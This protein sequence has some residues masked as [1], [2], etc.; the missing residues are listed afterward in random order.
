VWE[1]GEPPP[2]PAN[3]VPMAATVAQVLP[4]VENA[5]GRAL[6]EPE[7]AALGD[8]LQNTPESQ[9]GI[10]IRGFINGLRNVREDPG[11]PPE[12]RLTA[13]EAPADQPAPVGP[14]RQG[15]TVWEGAPA[16]ERAANAVPM[17]ET[18]KSA[19]QLAER[20]LGRPL[21]AEETALLARTLPTIPEAN[22]G[23]FLRRYLQ[24]LREWKAKDPE[25]SKPPAEPLPPPP[26][27]PAALTEAEV[28]QLRARGFSDDHIAKLT[29]DMAR[30]AIEGWPERVKAAVEPEAEPV[31][32]PEPTGGTWRET[33]ADEVH[34]PGRQFRMNTTTGK[35][36]VFEPAGT[37]T[38][39]TTAE[40]T[41]MKD[42]AGTVINVGDNVRTTSVESGNI[43]NW[44]VTGIKD[45]KF[46]P[47]VI[48]SDGTRT[49]NMSA[50]QIAETNGR[51]LVVPKGGCATHRDCGEAADQ[52]DQPPPRSGR[53]RG[54]RLRRMRGG[55]VALNNDRLMAEEQAGDRA[56]CRQCRG[57]QT[58]G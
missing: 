14:P 23:I 27:T 13:W 32:T 15:P 39:K 24:G 10:A 54:I 8:R 11:P 3:A 31:A 2:G 1:G 49:T 56:G 17:D 51:L 42:S 47:R 16:T 20:T 43:N 48:L 57:R 45:T 4:T 5:L 28:Q 36:E 29:P 41:G 40:P 33:N 34:P 58:G 19:A 18:V 37:G 9:R 50:R 35:S 44:T 52:G 55:W 38:G 22:R 6:T 25:A 26:E 30:T 46:G 12:S 53:L 21:S 7:R